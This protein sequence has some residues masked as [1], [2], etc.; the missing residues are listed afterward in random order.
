MFRP[1]LGHAG[2]K[3]EAMLVGNFLEK[4]GA[5]QLRPWS[6]ITRKGGKLQGE[7]HGEGLKL[8]PTD[9]HGFHFAHTRV[10][11]SLI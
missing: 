6:M 4:R 10:Q 11:G 3:M 9:T 2:P 7:I 1:R 5:F 8:S